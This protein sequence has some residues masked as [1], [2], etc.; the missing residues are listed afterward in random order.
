MK[1][2]IA[3]RIIKCIGL[4]CLAAGFVLLI[5]SAGSVD[6]EVAELEAVYPMV[7]KAVILLVI[8]FAAACISQKD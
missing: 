2:L 6:C 1:K 8:G 5:G 3:T 4:L 7:K